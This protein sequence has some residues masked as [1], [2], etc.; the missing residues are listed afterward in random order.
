MI[1]VQYYRSGEWSDANLLGSKKPETE[2]EA[3][4]LAE[5]RSKNG[6]VYR[7]RNGNRTIITYKDGYQLTKEES[8]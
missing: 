5:V 3:M 6:M 4:R 1:T 7:V 8:K 2:T